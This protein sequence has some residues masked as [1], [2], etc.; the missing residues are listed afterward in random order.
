MHL[1]M[2]RPTLPAGDRQLVQIVDA[3][4]ADATRRS[5]AWLA[6]RP[7]C[8]QCC[9][10]VFSISQLDALRLQYGLDE[11]ETTDLERATR[12]RSRAQ[13]SIARIAPDYP[14]NPKTGILDLALED[15]FA[16]FANDEPCPALDPATGT[17][18]LYSSRPITCRAFGPPV[19]SEDGSGETGL[20]VCELCYQGATEKEIAQ[21]EMAVDPGDLESK[22]LQVIKK[23][24][25]LE[26]ETIVAFALANRK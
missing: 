19:R 25:G 4:L 10:G 14:G 9:I 1:F 15:R 12:V 22:L 20:G 8:T 21:C 18:D 7:G 3:A 26:G 17:C 16:D 2:H 5:G 13:E 24:G 11:L 23:Q 6:C